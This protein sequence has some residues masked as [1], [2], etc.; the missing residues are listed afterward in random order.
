MIPSELRA[1][2]QK[3]GQASLAELTA[4]FAD[5]DSEVIQ[6]QL[7]YWQEKGRILKTSAGCGKACHACEG[8]AALYQWRAPTR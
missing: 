8:G 2:L 1:Y 7:R 4:H 6:D 3:Q 5:T